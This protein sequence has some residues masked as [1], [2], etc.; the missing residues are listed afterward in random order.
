MVK[1]TAKIMQPEEVLELAG[2]SPTGERCVWITA[3]AGNI[4]ELVKPL[5]D[6]LNRK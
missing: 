4:D 3:G 2:N 5:T 6:I 1:A